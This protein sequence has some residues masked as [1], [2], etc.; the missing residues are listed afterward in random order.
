VRAVL[1]HALV[2]RGEVQRL[3]YLGAMFRYERPQKGR[4]RQFSQIGAEIF[5]S[6]SAATDA[7]VVQMALALFDDLR[8]GGISL[9]IN[10]VGHPACREVYRARLKAFFE[11]LR[12]RLCE[13]DRRRLDTNP[14]RILDCKVPQCAEVRRGAPE[15]L[16]SLCDDCRAHFDEVMG[17]LRRMNVSFQVNPRLVR[18][19]DYYTRTTFEVVSDR[20]G[21]Q[22]A[23]CGG[24]RYDG[25]VESMGGPATPGFGFA[26]GADR[27]VLAL[28][29]SE[30]AG[31]ALDVYLVH[32]GGASLAEAVEAAAALR[33]RGLAAR[34]DPDAKD[35]KKQMSRA[36]AAAARFAL[37]IGE[38]ELEQGRYSL[39]NMADG[40]QQTVGA[41]QWDAIEKEIRNGR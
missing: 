28:A 33:Q 27:L 36:S 4:Y 1:E 30:P 39:K 8:L 40:S 24:G 29:G 34:L 21:A 2:G 14:L 22:D 25:L 6:A 38:Q 9:Q 37:I 13:D 41:R 35:L 31:L 26:I 10:S 5:G 3:C 18:G 20:L 19:L 7:E 17:H 11:P 15:I 16:D 32:R 12:D 23:I